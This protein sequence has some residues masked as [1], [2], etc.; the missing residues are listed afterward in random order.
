M[1]LCIDMECYLED[2]VLI[3]SIFEEAWEDRSVSLFI[4]GTS[5]K[6]VLR[7]HCGRI[8]DV[9]GIDK[10]MIDNLFGYS[11]DKTKESRKG[12][13]MVDEVYFDK[14]FTQEEQPRIRCGSLYWWWL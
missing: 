9:L 4:P 14:S 10:T 2:T 8:L 3:K 7:H 11:K 6:G 1:I 12:R 13:V 5:I